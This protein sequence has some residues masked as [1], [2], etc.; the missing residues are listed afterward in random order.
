MNSF[1]ARSGLASCIV[2]IE[3]ISAVWFTLRTAIGQPGFA[4]ELA[5]LEKEQLAK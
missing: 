4:Q 1:G 5:R 3:E 2:T